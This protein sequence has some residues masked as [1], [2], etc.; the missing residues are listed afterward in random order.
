VPIAR[1]LLQATTRYQFESLACTN[2]LGS[3]SASDACAA[4]VAQDVV[5][6]VLNTPGVAASDLTAL[7]S[8]LWQY[9]SPA[10]A[11]GPPRPF[12]SAPTSCPGSGSSSKKGLLGLLG[13]LALIPL[14]LCCCLLLLCL[15]RRKKR[16]GDVHFATFDPQAANMGGPASVPALGVSPCAF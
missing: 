4:N 2:S 16:E 3:Q 8:G 11:G 12:V 15:L 7:R 10:I 5:C 6:W 1:S 9:Q 13:L 14:I